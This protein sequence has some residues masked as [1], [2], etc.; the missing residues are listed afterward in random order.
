MRL[1]RTTAWVGGAALLALVLAAATWLLLV[2][3]RLDE[4]AS[5]REQ[6]ASTATS[7]A[8]LQ[9]QVRQLELQLGDVPTTR[10][11]V[12]AL[13]QQVPPE[14]DLPGLLRQMSALAE[15]A[16]AQLTGVTPT[17][18]TA[19]PA[20]ATA[21]PAATTDPAATD[22]TQEAQTDGGEAASDEPADAAT[23]TPT[24]A[25]STGPVVEVVPV[26]IT[27]EGSFLQVQELLRLLQTE[28]P[29]ALLV[30]AVTLTG[31]DGGTLQM[32]L[33]AEVLSLPT[34]DAERQIEALRA[35]GEAAPETGTQT[36]AGTPTASPA[37][38]DAVGAAYD[39]A[40][41]TTS[42][43]TGSGSGSGSEGTTSDDSDGDQP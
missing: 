41:P 6:T 15:R 18:A 16:G 5:L 36:G 25:A 3:P 9:T 13:R 19:T 10:A 32:S 23:A 8:A 38:L 17:E 34:T 12:A 7:N 35:A 30:R 4:A 31:G 11:E 40:D 29:R 43:S 2:S 26:T 42:T 27:A 28:M 39:P 20:E 21:T 22:G 33:T 37:P 14:A 24:A 1:T